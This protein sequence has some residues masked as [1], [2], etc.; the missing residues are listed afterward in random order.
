MHR[1]FTNTKVERGKL[2]G[3][4]T[5]N[6]DFDDVPGVCAEGSDYRTVEI[7]ESLEQW[8]VEDFE[9]IV[10]SMNAS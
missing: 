5:M 10:P 2:A 7:L 9:D 3:G 8:I 1:F 4:I 6:D